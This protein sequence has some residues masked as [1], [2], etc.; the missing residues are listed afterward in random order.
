MIHSNMFLQLNLEKANAEDDVIS[1]E[2]SFH[3]HSWEMKA[4]FVLI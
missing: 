4:A 3:S 2:N 1:K